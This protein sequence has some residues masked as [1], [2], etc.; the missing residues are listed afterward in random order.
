[1]RTPPRLATTL[2][3][4]F[5]FAALLG[6]LVEEYQRGNRSPWWFWRQ[7]LAALR[8]GGEMNKRLSMILLAEWL[9]IAPAIVFLGS[10]AVRSM[11]GRGVGF[12]VAQSIVAWTAP[13]VS[14][15]DAAMVFLAMPLAVLI[16]GSVTWMQRWRRNEAFRA[17]VLTALGVLRRN[18]AMGLLTAATCIG[19]GILGA[20][21]VHMITD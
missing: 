4:R 14:R 16:L 6:D 3:E 12:R 18:L 2:L 9:L 7:T 8:E 19:G 20:V 15:A 11:G 21:V 17:D 1:V 5:G 13:H 10:A